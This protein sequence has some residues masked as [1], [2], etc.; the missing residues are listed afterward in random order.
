MRTNYG[1]PC[2]RRGKEALEEFIRVKEF[3]HYD[4]IQ[5]PG[6]AKALVA[7]MNDI[8]GRRSIWNYIV[9]LVGRKMILS[10]ISILIQLHHAGRI[11]LT[12]HIDCGAFGGSSS[13]LLP[14]LERGI[15]KSWLRKSKDFL[16]KKFPKIPIEAYFVDYD[17]FWQVF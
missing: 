10:W 2:L 9:R 5:I 4:L 1:A 12:T 13:F 17:G 8:T 15:H 6:G 16:A 7:P 3:E 11:I 14:E